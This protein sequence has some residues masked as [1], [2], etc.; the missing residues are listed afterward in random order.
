M[1]KIG[2]HM[3]ISKGFRVVPEASVNIGGNTFQIFTH[4]PRSWKIIKIDE[5]DINDFKNNMKKYNINF[6]DALVHSSYLINLA[7]PKEDIW[8]NSINTM[9]EEIKFTEK[10]GITHYNFHPGS[11]LGKGE[12]YGIKRIIE[13]LNRVFKEIE[14]TKVIVLLENVAQKGGNIGYSM[15]QLGEIIHNSGLEN[16]LGITYDT[17][18]GFDSNYDI[19]EKSEVQRLLDDIEEY[20]GL[21]KLKMIHLNDSKYELGAGKDRHEF[22]GQGNIGIKGF[23]TFLSFEEILKL[24]L[25]LETPGDDAEHAK[26]IEV[27]KEILKNLGSL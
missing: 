23:E 17:C 11:H 16:R 19:R 27:I 7:S 12:E 9:I 14:N 5:K 15:Q 20:V 3:K 10:L 22:I 21:E 26:D 24:P 1:V 13:A 25:L 18:H 8:E 6:E 2:A 4:S